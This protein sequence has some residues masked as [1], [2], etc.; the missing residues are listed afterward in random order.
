MGELEKIVQTLKSWILSGTARG[1]Q[2]M[3]EHNL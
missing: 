3:V 2:G 1:Y